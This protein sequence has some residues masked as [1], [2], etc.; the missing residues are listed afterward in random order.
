MT[1]IAGTMQA[2]FTDR[3]VRQL[4]ASEHTIAAYRDTLRM[5]LV[6]ATA[7]T[8]KSASRLDFADLD[9]PLVAAFLDHLET[10]R[11]NSARTRN[12][13]LAAIHSLFAFAALR[14]PEHAAG[15]TRVLAIPAKR[16]EKT[17]V[18]YL[19]DAELDALLASPD[20][21]T[22]TGRRDHSLIVTMA[23]T[24]LRASEATGLTLADLNL[25]TAAHLRCHGKG[26]KD[27][28]T[29]LTSHTITVLHAWTRERG[30]APA[31]VLFPNRT[32][33]QLSRDALARRIAHH[34]AADCPSLAG[35]IVTPHVL[36]HTAA[37]RLLHAGVD[38]TVIALW[39]GP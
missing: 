38:V 28:V 14:H 18:T 35:K 15:I 3:L 36:R 10:D 32:G 25:G 26:R 16:S 27:R 31:D 33:Q 20:Q 5:L 4:K 8:G 2:F 22:W 29:P 9:A 17:I 7:R 12:A 1:P 24:G 19:T 11:R 6:F 37:M 39:L 13:R 30:G 34:A 21:T 23:Q